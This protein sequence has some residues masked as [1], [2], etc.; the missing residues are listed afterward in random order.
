MPKPKTM[1]QGT[2]ILC[3]SLRLLYDLNVEIAKDT[4]LSAK[5]RKQGSQDA[6]RARQDAEGWGCTWAQRV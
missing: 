4:K 6:E 3:D 5:D 2:K 1:K